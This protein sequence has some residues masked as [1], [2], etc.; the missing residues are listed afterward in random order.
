M[1][2]ATA[3]RRLLRWLRSPPISDPVD[4][5]NAPMLQIVLAILGTMPPLMWM[6]R[7]VVA[8]I[9]WRPGETTSLV[10]SMAISAMALF[11]LALVRHGRFQW[12]IRQLLV[13]IAILLLVT[14]AGSGLSANTY[15]QPLQVMWLFV[16]GLMVGRRALWAMYAS[17]AVALFLG[18]GTEI[19]MT[20]EPAQLLLVDALIRA[21]MFLLVAVVVDRSIAALRASLDEAVQR[22]QE[23]AA[24]NARLQEEIAAR[25]RTQEQL[26]HAQKVEAI[27]HMASGVAHDFNHLLSLILGYAERGR[28]SQDEDELREVMGGMESAARRASAITHKLLNFS[29]YDVTQPTEFDACQ[30]LEEMQPM[31]RQTLGAETRLHMQLPATPCPI[32]FDRAQFGL[33]ILNLTAN[34]AQAIHGTGRFEVALTPHDDG[35]A[36]DIDLRDSGPGISEEVQARMFEPFFTTKPAGQGTG[37]GLPIVQTLVAGF[38]GSL[39]VESAPGNGTTVRITLPLV[40]ESRLRDR[41]AA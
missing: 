24:V 14:Y 34:A 20:G 16:A 18:A 8:D 27:G 25:E 35:S 15:E 41:S 36:T 1:S 13:V 5:R 21:A 39:Q 30:A 32:L 37:L 40:A 23:L 10:A 38:G 22:G 31:L 7:I 6:Y 29:R 9:A 19:R 4:R 33:V 11:S 12:A 2:P 26:L 17:L 3:P 28:D